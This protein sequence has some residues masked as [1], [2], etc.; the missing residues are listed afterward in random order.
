[1]KATLLAIGL[2][3]GSSPAR[4]D[5]LSLIINGKSW[6]S[7]GDF[8]ERNPGIGLQYD[9]STNKF[10]QAST[11]RDSY[12]RKGY[13]VGGGKMWTVLPAIRVGIMGFYINHSLYRGIGALPVAEIGGRVAL[14][15]TYLPKISEEKNVSVLFV[16]L[17][18]KFKEAL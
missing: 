10:F 12:Y 14:N 8:N 7:H 5:D 9:T 18:V 1:M 17:K 11:F 16:Q 15:L 4:S 6:H 13:L 2:I 3:L